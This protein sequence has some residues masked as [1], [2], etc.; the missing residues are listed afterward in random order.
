MTENFDNTEQFRALQAFDELLLANVCKDW[1]SSPL[2]SEVPR[3]PIARKEAGQPAEFFARRGSGIHQPKDYMSTGQKPVTL[4]ERFRD[5]IAPQPAGVIVQGVPSSESFASVS[6][7]TKAKG[8]KADPQKA[9]LV[10]RFESS[11]V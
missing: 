5:L 7:S 3:K 8:A 9:E 11:D 1:Q 2:R 6:V 10:F 4:A